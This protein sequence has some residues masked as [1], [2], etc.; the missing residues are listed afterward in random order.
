MKR[1]FL[2]L[3]VVTIFSCNHSNPEPNP[4]NNED[5][6]TNKKKEQTISELKTKYHFRYSL[7]TLNL[8]YSIEFNDEIKS[9]YLL[10]NDFFTNDIFL[11]DSSVF[12]SIETGFLTTYYLKLLCSSNDKIKFLSQKTGPFNLEYTNAILVV[13]LNNLKKIDFIFDGQSGEVIQRPSSDFTGT[14]EIVE[15]VFTD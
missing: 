13:K 3:I 8:N 11:Q 12:V 4:I 1:F 10:V 6:I 15:A 5:D 2:L 9:E 7:D 14:G